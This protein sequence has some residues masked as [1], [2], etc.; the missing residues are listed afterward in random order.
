[1]ICANVAKGTHSLLSNDCSSRRSS[2]Y[3]IPIISCSVSCHTTGIARSLVSWCSF[4]HHRCSDGAFQR[5]HRAFLPTDEPAATS[6]KTKGSACECIAAATAATTTS[7]CS[8]AAS[9]TTT[10][11]TSRS[12][13]ST[14]QSVQQ[15]ASVSGSGVIVILTSWLLK[16][17]RNVGQVVDVFADDDRSNKQD[18]EEH[19]KCKVEDGVSNDT[20]PSKS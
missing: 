16:V 12:T 14:S 3:A 4:V 8:T 11:T 1:M 10:A 20:S 5:K 7:G 17:K 19:Q 18:D 13:C 6:T 15:R 2:V 9:A